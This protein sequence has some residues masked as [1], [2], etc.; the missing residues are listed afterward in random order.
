MNNLVLRSISGI[1]YVSIIIVS[2]ITT[3]WA[4]GSLCLLFAALG[5]LEFGKLCNNR[6]NISTLIFDVIIAIAIVG[7]TYTV[8]AK[9]IGYVP[10]VFALSV[11]LV[12]VRMVT[13][14]YIKNETNSLNTLAYSFTGICYVV[15]PMVFMIIMYHITSPQVLLAMFVMIW[16]NDSGA[17]IVGSTLGR[18]IPYKLFPRISPKKSWAGFVGGL[19]FAVASVFVFKY[20]FGD[21]Y[22]GM[23]T[24][25]MVGFAI[26]VTLFS[27]WGD[28][29]ESMM[30]RALNV[31]DSGNLIPGH[32]GIL[33]RIDSLLF[34][35]PAL[36]CYVIIIYSI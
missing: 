24:L 31:K 21:Y 11:L 12:L 35:V 17:Y 20:C 32:G 30:K 18:K 6:V 26:V 9:G 5:V 7:G 8:A 3:D 13:Q 16:L 19:L 33:D 1:V 23:S 28:L 10:A 15:M 29:I 2:L 14:L 4:F 34:V 25:V 36:F 22:K 27:T